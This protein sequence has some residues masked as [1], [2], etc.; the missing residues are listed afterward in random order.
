MLPSCPPPIH[1]SLTED[2]NA[3]FWAPGMASD[4]GVGCGQLQE[5]LIRHVADLPAEPT[6]STNTPPQAEAEA[7]LPGFPRTPRE[8]GDRHGPR[9]RRPGPGSLEKTGKAS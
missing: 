3:W 8:G 7:S 5:D 9:G 4:G 6:P 2:S 1:S